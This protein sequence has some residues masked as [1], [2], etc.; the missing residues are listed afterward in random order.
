VCGEGVFIVTVSGDLEDV[1]LGSFEHVVSS[2]VIRGAEHI[3]LDLRRVTSFGPAALSS[4]HSFAS[5]STPAFWLAPGPVVGGVLA[6]R[7]GLEVVETPYRA[8]SLIR[9]RQKVRA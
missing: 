4:L 6:A 2:D 1:L 3:I 9:S 5:A 7:Q 8:V